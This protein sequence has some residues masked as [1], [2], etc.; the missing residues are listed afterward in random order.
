M[1][2]AVDV[3]AAMLKLTVPVPLPVAP[4]VI[5]IHAALLVADQAQPVPAVTVAEPVVA[6]APADCVVGDTE[7]VQAAAAWLTVTVTPA[8]VA[9]AVR[10]TVFG[11]AV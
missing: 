2:L 10:A 3:F 9:V 1:R 4:A 11:F 6:A 5:V 8:T 7:N